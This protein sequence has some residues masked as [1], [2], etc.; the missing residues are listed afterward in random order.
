MCLPAAR[1]TLDL[2]A[3]WREALE[4]AGHASRLVLVADLPPASSENGV[5]LAES[6]PNLLWVAGQGTAGLAATRASV[7][8]LRDARC[9]LI[10]AVMNSI[11]KTVRP[12]RAVSLWLALGLASRLAPSTAPAQSASPPAFAPAPL[13]QSAEGSR[14]AA[15]VPK[16]APWQERLTLG[17]GDVMSIRLHDQP[18]SAKIGLF[19]GPDGRL[20]Y[21]QA[22]DV[23]AAG[24]T[25]DELRV[26]LEG[27]LAKYYLTPRVVINP[28]AYNSKKYFL[29]GNVQTVGPFPLNRPV[30]ILEAVA[31]AGGFVAS[32]ESRNVI[33]QADLSRSFLARTDATGA[34]TRVP[35]DFEAVL[36]RGEL[37]QNLELTPGDYLY[38][39]PIDVQEI[40]VLGAVAGPGVTPYSPGL[41]VIGAIASRGGF[42]EK[43]QRSKVVV[44]RG[45]LNDPQTFIVDASAI[46][47]ASGKDFPLQNKDIVYVSRRPTAKVEEL[48]EAAVSSFVNGLIWGFTQNRIIPNLP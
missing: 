37:G 29:L 26:K 17:P 32:A 6:L 33:I 18:D 15:K 10:G 1:L 7:N 19:I 34:A 5:L 20:N 25:V 46:L 8:L 39:P 2:R 47:S 36:M 13:G 44:I 12:R 43:A 30:T 27:I 28:S 21:L 31:R 14:S 24:L 22:H 45:S 48:T 9:N 40:Y 42:A 38:F 16:L 41:G 4:H 23:P 3:Q 11:P 35:V